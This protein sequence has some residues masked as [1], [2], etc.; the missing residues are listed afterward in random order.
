MTLIYKLAQPKR[1]YRR[2]RV[3]T[4]V[5]H[6]PATFSIITNICLFKSSEYWSRLSP[7][8]GPSVR[9]AWRLPIASNH[10]LYLLLR[11][12]YSSALRGFV[13]V[14]PPFG[15]LMLIFI[16][17]PH[18][19]PSSVPYLSKGCL[20]LF[21]FFGLLITAASLEDLVK[22]RGGWKADQGRRTTVAI[23]SQVLVSLMM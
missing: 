22:I 23:H 6:T 11:I 21:L 13:L 1:C 15:H 9:H 2:L 16:I 8:V 14:R 7:S 17:P 10:N 20:C 4:F 18:H 5:S 3:V 12:G 19:R